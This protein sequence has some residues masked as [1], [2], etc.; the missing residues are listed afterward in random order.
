MKRICLC[1]ILLLIFSANTF[2]V[3]Y[4]KIEIQVPDKT[5]KIYVDDKLAGSG[6]VIVK[7]KPGSHKIKVLE[8]GKMVLLEHKTVKAGQY[9]AMKGAPKKKVPPPVITPE[10]TAVAT[11]EDQLMPEDLESQEQMPSHLIVGTAEAEPL[12]ISKYKAETEPEKEAEPAGSAEPAKEEKDKSESNYYFFPGMRLADDYAGGCLGY[13]FGAEFGEDDA[14]RYDC[15]LS[16]FSMQSKHAVISEGDLG[17]TVIDLGM[18]K[19]EGEWYWGG[20]L[21]YY[22]FNNTIAASVI[23]EKQALNLDYSESIDSGLGYYFKAGRRFVAYDKDWHIG[24]KAA[25]A[26]TTAKS[27]ELNTI[28]LVETD[29]E[30][31]Y[32]FPITSIYL[33]IVL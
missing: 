3:S 12:F 6:T 7:V 14:L 26:S 19:N 4:G 25:L 15:S 13:S 27:H 31:P 2:A 32:G 29:N 1:T 11:A 16:M 9:I 22:M 18:I 8:N 28:T 33:G 24:F 23:A 30:L 20:G 17:V 10:V 21:G 5:F